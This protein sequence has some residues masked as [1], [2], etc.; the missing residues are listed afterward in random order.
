MHRG[1]GC[2]QLPVAQRKWLSSSPVCI[3]AVTSVGLAVPAA[4][5]QILSSACAP[6]AC[7]WRQ[8]GIGGKLALAGGKYRQ[9]AV[10][11]RWRALLPD[12]H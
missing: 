12:H 8:N 7:Q 9:L 10:N 5:E 1:G 4:A 6:E 11:W 2:S 3:A